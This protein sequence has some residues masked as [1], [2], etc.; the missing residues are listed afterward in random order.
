[1]V[2]DIVI[3]IFLLFGALIGFKNGFTKSL[4]SMLGSFIVLIL[5]FILKVPVANLLMSIFPFFDFNGLTA[6]NVV[7]YQMIAFTLLVLILGII[8]KI[9]L[10]ATTI[11]EKILNA[12]I[13]L[14][15]ASK[16][17]G[18][19]VGFIRNYIIIFIVLYIMSFPFFSNVSFINESKMKPFILDHTLILSKVA[20]GAT[21]LT[22]EVGELANDKNTNAEIIKILVKYNLIN[23][24]NVIDKV[25]ELALNNY[26]DDNIFQERRKEFFDLNDQRNCE[27]IYQAIKEIEG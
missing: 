18:A 9:L 26:I 7:M 17:L 20:E 6:L 16:V 10:Y 27:R 23:E 25:V 21:E 11:F 19:F 24:E 15:F 8:V 12:T 5:A 22:K 2:L 4:V 1:M 3:L 14:G 13:I